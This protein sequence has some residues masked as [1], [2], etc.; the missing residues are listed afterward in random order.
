M[1]L[2]LP[3]T[4]NEARQLNELALTAGRKMQSQQTGYIH[5][6]YAN[7]EEDVQHTI[8]IVENACFV[9]ALLRSRTSE[10]MA[11]A[12]DIL[13]KFLYFQNPTE[14]NFPIYLH[15]Y[16]QCKDRFLGIQLL[17]A[18]YYILTEF[19]TVLGSDLKQ[20]LKTATYQLLQHTLVVF[21]EKTPSYPLGLKMAALCKVLGAYFKDSTIEQR[22]EHLLDQFLSMGMQSHWFIPTAI[23]D[24]CMVLQ[25]VYT[26]LDQSPWYAFYQHLMHTW[27]HPTGSYAGPALKQY[28]QGEEPQ[29][30]LYDLF[31][32]YFMRG[33]SSRALKEA[34]YHLQAVF[35]RPT[36]ECLQPA[37]LPFSLEGVINDDNKSRWFIYQHEKF[38]YSLIEKNAM[39]NPALENSF[40]PLSLIWGDKEKVHSFVCQGGNFDSFE[41]QSQENKIELALQLSPTYDL[42]SREKNR[43]V[44]FFFDIEPDVK[45]TM[46]GEVATTF[47]LAEEF[48][49]KTTQ[50]E[51]SLMIF[52][53]D[54]EGQF[55]GHLMQG[56]RPSQN[57]L[58]GIHRFKAYD[59]QLFF[60]TLRRSSQC[61][62]NV[63]L[64][65]HP[66]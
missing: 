18:F 58:K 12:K 59:W 55:L 45:M 61:Q 28:Q 31:L 21:N 32:G 50:M 17:P 25:M 19:H 37:Q 22:G 47:D 51:L 53:E 24:I 60:R 38:A 7:S 9:L 13:D 10:Q 64:K 46:Q 35:I 40:H 6:S 5:F 44:I 48:V 43:E 26:Q 54:G 52:L 27:H 20:R 36:G 1:N 49:L 42:E 56:N 11:E 29:P 39:Q 30:T 15:E 34:P 33:F 14:G 4:V 3:T 66:C 57:Q 41:F 16:P 63:T 62:L 8:P 2:D 65:I 23:A